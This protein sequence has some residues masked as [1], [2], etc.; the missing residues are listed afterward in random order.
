[1]EK[2]YTFVESEDK[3]A[4]N[5]KPYSRFKSDEGRWYTC[6][7]AVTSKQIKERLN[8]KLLLNV[9]TSQKPGYENAETIQNLVRDV[10][11]AELV[12]LSKEK[13]IEFKEKASSIAEQRE[14][15]QW[16]EMCKEIYLALLMHYDDLKSISLDKAI[17]DTK[18]IR[19]A[20]K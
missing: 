7:S 19:E 20:F 11:G 16:A 15:R 18:K 17:E 2:E 5:G 13:A 10:Y 6:F 9:F 1:M 12:D 14:N 8:R 4:K 3:V